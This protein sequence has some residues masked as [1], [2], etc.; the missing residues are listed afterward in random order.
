MLDFIKNDKNRNKLYLK[1]Y[2]HACFTNTIHLF[3]P[4]TILIN[5]FEDEILK[6][7]NDKQK[8]IW[9]YIVNK[10][11]ETCVLKIKKF[12]ID[13]WFYNIIDLFDKNLIN[14]KILNDNYL[15]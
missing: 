4:L 2:Q 10:Y 14:F 3:D 13:M 5:K 9:D 6:L 15:K 12:I 7:L 1:I 8:Y 11:N